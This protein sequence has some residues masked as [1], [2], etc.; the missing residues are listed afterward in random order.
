VKLKF[1]GSILLLFVLFFLGQCKESAKQKTEASPYLNH[2]DSARYLGISACQSCHLDKYETYIETGM[3]QS[4]DSATLHKT[5]AKFTNIKPVY[6]S[7]LNLYYM[8]FVKNGAIYIKEYRIQNKDT[9]YSRTER[10]S[11]IVGSGHHTNSHFTEENGYY[12]QAPLTF[13]TQKGQWDLPPGF[14]N[15]NNTRFN[16]KIGLECMSCHNAM[17]SIEPLS[18]NKFTNVSHGINC[19]RCHGPGSIHV[20]KM[21]QG[22]T[23]DITKETDFSIVN[24]RKLSWQRQI[25]I[26][27]RC[28]LQGNAVLKPNKSFTDFKPGMHLSDVFD[29]FSPEYEGGDNFVMAAHAERFQKSQCFIQST[30]GNLN[31]AESRLGFTCISCHNPHVSVRKTNYIN[32]N[33]VCKGCHLEEKKQST[34]T[35]KKENIALVENNCV[36]CHMPSSGTSDIPHVTVHDHYIRKSS[37]GVQKE[38]KLLGLRCITNANVDV[39]TETKAYISY[40]EK[41]EQNPLYLIKAKE[42][43]DKPNA[44]SKEH[45]ETI[46]HLYYIQNDFNKILALKTDGFVFDDVW[47]N[48]RISKAYENTNNFEKSLEWM[49]KVAVKTPLNIDFQVQYANCLIKNNQFAKA[50]TVLLAVN[51]LYAKNEDAHAFLGLVYLKENAFSL[52]KA[53]FLK[54]LSLNPDLLLALKNLETVYGLN[55]QKQ[56]Q[57][58]VRDRIAVIENR[59]VLVK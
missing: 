57:L 41:F 5:A 58:K 40:F 7:F 34:C 28:H 46:V 17:P 24:P 20:E 6:D 38:G 27:Q 15:G 49:E 55:G 59:R 14:E 10:I 3:G 30:K 8:P 39:L 23:V 18:D 13:Y 45:L 42:K 52:A 29:Q 26:C 21:Q 36:K 56:E 35:D 32:Y 1:I 53:S 12:F 25:D 19:E 50:K 11:Y 54:A 47:T 51:Q 44:K 9:V 48:Y 16:R 31:A 4:F 33:N 37:N 43:M 2:H 22:K